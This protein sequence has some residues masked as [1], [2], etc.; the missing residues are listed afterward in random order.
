M[1]R[2]DES[3]RKRQDDLADIV[4]GA[5]APSSA[6]KIL[7]SMVDDDSSERAREQAKENFEG[8]SMNNAESM[9]EYIA[10]AKSLALNVSITILR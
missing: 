6:W 9:K 7:K 4:V 5:K 3:S 10:R 8:L 2:P 1:G